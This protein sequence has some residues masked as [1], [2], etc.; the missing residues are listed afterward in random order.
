ML[1][2]KFW[3]DQIKERLLQGAGA[4]PT[5]WEILRTMGDASAEERAKML[6]DDQHASW[7]L[8]KDQNNENYQA[9]MSRMPAVHSEIE[10]LTIL[11]VMRG[12]GWF[13]GSASLDESIATQGALRYANPGKNIL[14][15]VPPLHTF[16]YSQTRD[17]LME[18]TQ[19]L[20]RSAR[21]PFLEG[22][23]DSG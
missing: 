6:A 10:A 8:Q 3:E 9:G 11:W 21:L 7:R 14:T 18:T 20:E 23:G 1:G 2:K 4:M 17:D 19:A 12:G 5:I 22:P 16:R 15:H 13:T